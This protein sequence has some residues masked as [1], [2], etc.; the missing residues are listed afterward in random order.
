ML[1]RAFG[2]T[3]GLDVVVSNSS[4]NYGPFQ[5]PEK[6]VPTVAL[7]ALEDRPIPIYGDGRNVRDWLY[8]EDHADALLR[9]LERGRTG[10]TYLVGGDAEVANLD[11]ADR[12]CAVLDRM[13]PRADGRPHADAITHVA[14]RPGHDFRYA[15]DTSKV[16]RE[17]DWSPSVHLDEGLERTVRWMLDHPERVAEA[18]ARGFTTRRLGLGR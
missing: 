6:F 7:S 18:R 15:L 10:E 3:Y 4:N 12:L 14:D 13:R 9:V 17:L 11:L 5:H 8:V 16:R 2:V 1:V